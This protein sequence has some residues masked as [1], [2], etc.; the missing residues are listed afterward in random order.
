M[1][2]I[3]EQHNKVNNK[4]IG[5]LYLLTCALVLFV[6]GCETLRF[7]PSEVQ[8]KNAWLHNRTA[9]VTA[10]TAKEED[11]SEKLQALTKLNE[12]QSRAFVTYCGLPKEFPQAETAE[13]ILRDT[14]VQLARTALVEAADRPDTWQIADSALELAIGISALLGGVYGT[15]AVRFLNDAR[16]KSQ[17]LKEIIVGNELFKKQNES[18][19]SAFK[20]AQR[21][22]SPQTRQIVTQMKA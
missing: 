13:D 10:E 17:A 7:A 4:R 15:R 21:N 3:A 5:L 1:K 19:V 18:S 11:S 20:D 8:K 2:K 22:Q 6:C 9:Q 12:L 16:T 14:N